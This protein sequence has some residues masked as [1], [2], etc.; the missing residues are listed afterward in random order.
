MATGLNASYFTG[1]PESDD[2]GNNVSVNCLE[3]LPMYNA[4]FNN[5]MIITITLL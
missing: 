1:K 3:T 4:Q 5:Q 2:L